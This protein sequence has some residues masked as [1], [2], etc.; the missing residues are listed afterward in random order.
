MEYR[1]VLDE[2]YEYVREG[3]G[4][5][6]VL[7]HGLFGALSNWYATLKLFS[8]THT[9][10]IPIL[11]I[12]KVSSP[13]PPSVEGLADYIIAFLRR[14]NLKD[15]N[16]IGNSL[17][18][19]VGLFVVLQAGERVNSLVLTGSSGLFEAGMGATFP[20]RGDYEYIRERVAYTFYDPNTASKELVDEVFELVNDS[21]RAMR[22]LKIARAAQ[23]LN[24]R[25]R[26]ARINIPT[27]L[28]WGLN[29]NIT[30]TYVAHEFHSL[31]RGS[32]LHFIDRCGHAA[33]MEQPDVFNAIVTDFL[34]RRRQAEYAH[35]N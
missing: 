14:L 3:E 9:V 18:G 21:A 4:P 26:I 10:Y 1:L 11:P 7:L 29:D 5:P 12:S 30:P 22:I 2:D 8:Q 25:E 19:H 28:V 6:I 34:Q 24:M 32:S 16:L 20:R 33:M 35:V 31:I 13:V 27:C 15:V 17:G 23:R